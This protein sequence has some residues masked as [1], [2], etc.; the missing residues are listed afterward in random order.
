MSDTIDLT[1]MIDGQR[2]DPAS[3]RIITQIDPANGLKSGEFAAAGAEAIDRAVL[4]SRRAF[5]GVWSAL[6]PVA[7]AGMLKSLAG[8]IEANAPRIAA[9]DCRDMGKPIG[10]GMFEAG[11]VAAGFTRY[12]GEAVD[13]WPRGAVPA[14]DAGAF[15]MQVR[16]PRGV[17]GAIIPW[18]FPAI[19]LMMKIAPMLAAGNTVVVKPSELSPGSASI[20]AELAMEAGLPPGVLNLVQGDGA[21]GDALVRH[22]GIDMVAF[23]GS[24]ATGKAIMRA[25]GES[26]LKPVLL[27]CGGKSPEVVFADMAGQDLDA[28][29]AAI[30]GGAMQN[31]GQICVARSRLYIEAPIYDELVSRI[32][33]MAKATK[34]G[35]P[36]NP[37]TRFGPLASARQKQIVEGFIAEAE[38]QGGEILCDGRGA[39]AESGGFYV[40]PTIIGQSDSSARIV[41]QEIFGPVLAVSRFEGENE[42]VRL[43]NAT[44]YGLAATVWTRDLGRAHRMADRIDAGMTKIMTAPVQRIGAGFSHSA[45]AAKQSGFGI[46]GGF[47]ALDSYSRLQA[48]EFH[49]GDTP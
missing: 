17:I 15:E 39:L 20:I 37:E 24:T 33:T 10:A 8:L 2:A 47:G 11:M 42:A 46:E 28:I 22:G 12:Y 5:D 44:P 35:D 43:A 3:H 30:L 36:S 7:R 9:A 41:Q 23:T 26:T 21:T 49:Y 6:P 32:V 13:K 38:S 18:N 29:A 14:T 19:N 40:E 1:P 34:A 27:E 16:R 4:S 31:Q 25:V 45:E 48:V